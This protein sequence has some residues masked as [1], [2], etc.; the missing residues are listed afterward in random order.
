MKLL[1]MLG[2]AQKF[3]IL[4]AVAILMVL[5]PTTL[6][7]NRTLQD[8]RAAQT[9][10]RGIQSL[11]LLNHLVQFTQAHRGL[12]AA[13]LSGN[14]ALAARRPAMRD[15]VAAAMSALDG[16]L[17]SVG[18]SL[19]VM[20]H[21]EELRKA[22]SSVEQGV[23]SKE[24]KAPESTKLHT[25]LVAGELLLSEQLIDEFGLSLD[26][27]VDTYFLIQASL[28]NMPWLSENLGVMRAQGSS[29]LTLGSVPPEGKATLTGLQNRARQLQ[30]DMFRNLKKATD[31]NPDMKSAL[32]SSADA[33]SAAVDKALD[34][35]SKE[36]I[37]ASEIKLAATEYF[38][39]FTRTIDGLFEFNALA[40]KALTERL[41]AN[42]SQLQS[43]TYLVLL[44]LL[45]CGAG[46]VALSMAF[47][48]SITD[49]VHEAV[50]VAKAVAEGDLTVVVPVRGTNELGQLMLSLTQMRD[51]LAGVVARVRHGSENIATASSEIAQ[52]DQDLSARTENQASALE[53]TSASMEE[54]DSTIKQNADSAQQ[55]NQLAIQASSVAVHGGEVVGQVVD[56]MRGINESSRKISDIIGVIDGI[57]F[58]TNILA[59]NAAVE[60]ARAGEQGRGFA[61]VA[62]EVRSLAGRSAEAA[63]EIKML[64]S[65]SVERVEKGTGL[66]DRA[67]T[68]MQ[69]IV[70]TIA[71]LAAIM[72]EI[73][74]ASSEQS[75]GVSQVDE[76]V[77]QMDSV[78]QQNAAL[79]EQI[80][81]A[82][83][84]LKSQ[85]KELVDVVSI[86]R[87]PPSGSTA[88]LSR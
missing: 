75:T 37:G 16:E 23:S 11:V 84:S 44:V 6:Y 68:T 61:V 65:A 86:F 5:L 72:G 78:T 21:W 54:L 3:A 83:V 35:A 56:T 73:S 48:R 17:K 46:A 51:H 87:L 82:A 81:A 45:V 27:N 60:A 26:P 20:G 38:G 29:F 85:A 2:L 50:A 7:F 34:L 41:E 62:S 4:G 15:K 31:T 39:E 33:G 71:R 1:H 30:G 43:R 8:T 88:Y 59:L 49:P 67:G 63:K 9:E 18:A 80:A 77:K 69:E 52:G 53:E 70:Q 24:L 74:T 79:V 25:Q 47:I 28:V 22:W 10:A 13:M 14:E 58:Q 40:M 42:A 66:V 64:I 36:V 12:S 32:Q 19:K 57:A 55:A 76:A